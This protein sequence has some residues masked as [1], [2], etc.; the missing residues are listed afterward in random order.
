M[1]DNE[2]S[3][4]LGG[5]DE[6]AG[7]HTEFTPKV[8]VQEIEVKTLEEDEEV[9]FKA[10]SK[11]FVFIAEDIYGG[12]IRKNYWK[13]R[14]TGDVKLLKHKEMKKIRLLMRQEKTLKICANHLVSPFVELGPNVGSDRSWVFTASDFAEEELKVET[15]AIKFA[16]AEQ[17]EAFKEKIA[18]AKQVNAGSVSADTMVA[19]SDDHDEKAE[20]DKAIEKRNQLESARKDSVRLMSAQADSDH[21]SDAEDVDEGIQARIQSTMGDDSLT[22]GVSRMGL[23]GGHSAVAVDDD[24]VVEAGNFAVKAIN[25]GELVKIAAATKQVV[26]GM[27][28][29]L[30]LHIKH[31]DESVHVYEATV[32]EPLPHTSQPMMLSGHSHKG[33]A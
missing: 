29:T 24:K 27:N 23:A 17:A 14:G 16:N 26:A 8:R 30:V 20:L 25:K 28:F 13:E 5:A 2:E 18:L 15:F 10:R 31:S 19:I 12:E 11:L 32:F 1:S 22:A 4:I 6:S 7:D 9:C 21:D 3:G 33:Q